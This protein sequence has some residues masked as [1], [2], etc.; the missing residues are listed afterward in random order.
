M[1]ALILPVGAALPAWAGDREDCSWPEPAGALLKT[2]PDRLALACRRQ[3]E[4]RDAYAQYNVGFLYETGQGV[5]QDHA[6]AMMWWQKAAGQ[7][8]AI[9]LRELER[10]VRRGLT[11]LARP[12]ADAG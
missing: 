3:A 1:A 4:R 9:A 2:A 6:A 11:A 5:P 10:T 12:Q 8:D 7:G